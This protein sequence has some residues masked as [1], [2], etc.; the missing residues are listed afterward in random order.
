MSQFLLNFPLFTFIQYWNE[1]LL[2][3]HKN[4]GENSAEICYVMGKIKF[5]QNV[6]LVGHRNTSFKGISN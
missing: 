2:F 5:V 6:L 1:L 3:G 4:S